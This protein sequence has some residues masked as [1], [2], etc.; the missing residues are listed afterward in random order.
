MTD[1]PDI[2][3]GYTVD[4]GY[5][6]TYEEKLR[7]STLGPP[8]GSWVAAHIVDLTPDLQVLLSWVST[9]TSVDFCQL[10]QCHLGPPWNLEIPT[11]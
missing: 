7:A 8:P 10:L 3:W 9:V 1:I 11:F 5:K 6:P 2:F 4:A